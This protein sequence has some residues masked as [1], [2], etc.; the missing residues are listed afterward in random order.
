MIFNVLKCIYPDIFDEKRRSARKIWL[1][2]NKKK[3]VRK[4]KEKK[5][6]HLYRVRNSLSCNSTWRDFWLRSLM[7]SLQNILVRHFFAPSVYNSD[8]CFI[9]VRTYITLLQAEYRIIKSLLRIFL[10]RDCKTHFWKKKSVYFY[11]TSRELHVFFFI[12]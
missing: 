7:L 9:E 2:K 4:K 10:Y 8:I 12:H 6:S 3:S 5:T 1:K 11:S